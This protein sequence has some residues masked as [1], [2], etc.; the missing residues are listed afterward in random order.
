MSKKFI[1]FH[2]TTKEYADNIIKQKSF[3]ASNDDEEWLGRGIYFFADYISH[4]R[5]WC[6][7]YKCYP[8]WSIIFSNIEAEKIID[9][10]EPETYEEFLKLAQ[11]FK[12]RYLK[13]SDGRP[14]RIIN[15][16]VL[17]AMYKINPYDI[18]KGT[19]QGMPGYKLDYSFLNKQRVNVTPHHVQLCIKNSLCIK[20]MEEV[21]TNGH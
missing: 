2:G 16:V 14:R 18:V 4:A 13:R 15:A 6:T 9:L 3:I 19:F 1:G 12:N 11:E 10:D 21:E 17:N 5:Y 7:K 8:Q 20:S